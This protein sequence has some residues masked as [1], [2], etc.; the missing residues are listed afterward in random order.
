MALQAGTYRARATKAL[1]AQVGKNETP[2]MQ[3]V[4]QIQDEGPHQ[5]ET[6]RWDGW[7]TDKTQDRT[8][9]SLQHCGWTGDDISTFAKDGAPMQG[10]DL[11]DVE[12]VVEL[13][14]YE[15]DGEKKTA[16]KIA[17]VNRIGGGRGLNVENAMPEAKALAFAERM[18]GIVLKS[19]AKTGATAPA[20]PAASANGGKPAF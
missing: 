8:I 9:E 4:F 1:L 5:G 14:T 10:M 18:K 17:W 7:L 12:L 6:I 20:S 19:R 11:N 2:A 3:V 15:K 13:E 16:A